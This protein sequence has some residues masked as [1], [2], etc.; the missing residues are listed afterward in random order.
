MKKQR[1]TVLRIKT[2]FLR[3]NVFT[4]L[5]QVGNMKVTLCKVIKYVSNDFPNSEYKT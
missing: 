5:K 4:M 1:K 2:S 3:T